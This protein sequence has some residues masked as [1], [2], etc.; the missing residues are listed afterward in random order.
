MVSSPLPLRS[1]AALIAACVT[2]SACDPSGPTANPLGSDAGTSPNVSAQ[3]RQLATHD[4]R[5]PAPRAADGGPRGLLY[6][7]GG[8]VLPD[9][10]PPPPTPFASDE[11]TPAEHLRRR[12]LAGVVLEAKWLWKKLPKPAEVPE[13]SKEGIED[14]RKASALGWRVEVA[15]TGRLRA[16]F[17]S[18]ALPLPKRAA[19]TARADRFGHI[20][21]WPNATRFR[22]VAPGTLRTTLGERRVD[23]TPLTTGKIQEQGAG[24]RLELE[25]RKFLL[26]SPLGSVSFETVELPEAGRGAPLLCRLLAEIIGVHPSTK[27][28]K[29]PEVVVWADFAWKDGGGVAFEVST[30]TRRTDLPAA[31]F[32]VP[33]PGARFAESGL[34][35]SPAG[36]F[37]TRDQLSVLRTEPVDPPQRPEGPEPGAPGEGFTAVNQSDH[38]L[39]LLL[40]SVPVVATPPWSERYVIGPRHGRYSVQWRTFLGDVVTESA[41]IHLPARITYGAKDAGAP[42]HPPDGGK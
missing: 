15:E 5:S 6:G 13:A 9:A 12:E 40:D 35:A 34:P 33:P 19:L 41:E 2:L 4:A 42:P 27:A 14:A 1:R 38:L 29:P 16:V 10:A 32:L 30:V 28:C 7:D 39:Y 24:K 21:L 26:K 18:V 25:T 22:T 36:V 8:F 31:D 17:D 3:P 23:V 11:V 37:F 20:V